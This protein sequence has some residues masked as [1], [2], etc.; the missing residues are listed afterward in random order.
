[1]SNYS[2]SAVFLSA[3][4]GHKM[5]LQSHKK[6]FSYLD[7]LP[8]FENLPHGSL[9]ISGLHDTEVDNRGEIR[10]RIYDLELV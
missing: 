3:G 2:E 5:T 1:M 6:I 4:A 8:E 10:V 9:T 7:Y